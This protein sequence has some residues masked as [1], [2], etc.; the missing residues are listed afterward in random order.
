MHQLENV[1][2]VSEELWIDGHYL[3]VPVI[4]PLLPARMP[5][6][7]DRTSGGV[8]RRGADH[9]ASCRTLSPI[10]RALSVLLLGLFVLLGLRLLRGLSL[11]LS[12][13]WWWCLRRRLGRRH[14]R[15][16]ERHCQRHNLRWIFHIGLLSGFPL[17]RYQNADRRGY[18]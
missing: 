6:A 10:S 1:L 18:I 2:H 3:L 8:P 16:R 13:R 7:D 11:L 15:H 12:L 9:S 14:S 4:S 17:F 5:S